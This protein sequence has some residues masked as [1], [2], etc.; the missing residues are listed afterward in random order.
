[1]SEVPPWADVCPDASWW[2]PIEGDKIRSGYITPAF[3]GADCLMRGGKN[4]HMWGMVKKRCPARARCANTPPTFRSKQEALLPLAQVSPVVT[5]PRLPRLLHT[6]THTTDVTTHTHKHTHK[7][8]SLQR[9]RSA[10]S[11]S[12]T[13]ALEYRQCCQQ[14]ATHKQNGLKLSPDK[15]IPAACW[16]QN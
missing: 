2:S 16:R 3:L 13:D 1:M 8:T 10:K 4:R 12:K 7:H 15:H 11:H 14:Q 5:Q 6:H 9:N